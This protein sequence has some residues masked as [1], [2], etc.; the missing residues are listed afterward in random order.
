MLGFWQKLWSLNK[1]PDT[2]SRGEQL[3]AEWLQRERGYH[4]VTRNWRRPADKR[5]EIDLV[6][7]DSEVL[8]FVEVKARG[9]RTSV[10]GYDAVNSRKKRA[11]QRAIEGYLSL[12]RQRP[13]TFRFD[14]VEVTF[15]TPGSRAAPEVLHF[16]NV[17]L[18]SKHFRPGR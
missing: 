6:C 14:V 1:P 2:G 17:P 10:R 11:V 15:P 18:F 5:D 4:L 9:S 7:R 13:S 12:L 3:A 8:V 16:E